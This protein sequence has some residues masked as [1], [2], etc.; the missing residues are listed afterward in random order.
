MNPTPSSRSRSLV[1]ATALAIGAIVLACQAAPPPTPVSDARMWQH[2]REAMELH[3]ALVDGDVES[4]TRS[5]RWITEREAE[6]ALP[7]NSGRFVDSLN[8]YADQV[9]TAQSLTQAAMP[10]ANVARMCGD[11][12]QNYAVPINFTLLD[13]PS[14]RHGHDPAT[15][16]QRHAWGVDRLWEGLVAPSDELWKEGA[17]VFVE[18]GL[19]PMDFPGGAAASGMI[20]ELEARVHELGQRAVLAETPQDR[21]TLFAELTTTCVACHEGFRG[22]GP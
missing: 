17:G 9:A 21:A 16:M 7:P 22:V 2:Y 19:R 20:R 11:C 18:A 14:S 12:H 4:A 3:I 1:T 10:A 13:P 6:H 15:E 5:A 8:A